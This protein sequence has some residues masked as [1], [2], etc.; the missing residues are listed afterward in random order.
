MGDEQD[1]KRVHFGNHFLGGGRVFEYTHGD[2]LFSLVFLE[3]PFARGLCHPLG[4]KSNDIIPQASLGVYLMDSNI[5]L[6]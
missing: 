3:V 2:D 4:E 1:F 6:E 5:S